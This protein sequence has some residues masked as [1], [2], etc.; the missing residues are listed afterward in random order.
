M[1]GPTRIFVATGPCFTTWRALRGSPRTAQRAAILCG[2][3]VLAR[4]KPTASGPIVLKSGEVTVSMIL[5]QL[6]KLA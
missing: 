6:T 1:Q 5:R 2:A 3:V 4:T